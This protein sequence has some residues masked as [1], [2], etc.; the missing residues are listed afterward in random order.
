MYLPIN[1]RVAI[2]DNEVK[3]VKPLFQIFS[4][5]RI[6]YTFFDTSDSDF[7]PSETEN[8]NDIRLLFLDLNFLDK[9]T[10]DSKNVKSMLVTYLKRVISKNNFPYLIILWSTQETTYYEVVV[11]IFENDLKDRAPI[12]IERFIKSDYIDHEGNILKD[13]DDNL[14]NAIKDI[15]TKHQAYSTLVY[16]ENKVHKSADMVLQNIFNNYNNDEWVNKAN[17]I[18]EKLS[19]GYLG[20]QNHKNS[21]YI[22]RTKGSLQAFNN[23]FYDTLETQINTL[24]NIQQQNLLEFDE[25]TLSKD[26]ILD[27][28]N[29]KLIASDTELKLYYTGIVGEDTN[30]KSDAI[31]KS[32]FTEALDRSAMENDIEG[33]ED[34]NT[35]AKKKH[36]SNLRDSIRTDWKKIYLVVT[37]LCDTVQNKHKNIRTV[38]GFIIEKKFK[39]YIDEKS[40]AIY[41]SPPFY[42]KDSEKSFVLVL[43]F[44]YFFTF[45]TNQK[46]LSN[47]KFITP[48]FRLRS[49][50]IAEIQSK[51]ARHVNRQGILYVE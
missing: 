31:F 1:G 40:E 29:F 39:K 46:V 25:S 4:K 18:I 3:E 8:S 12:S 42:M 28:L 35:K 16:W 6:P 30:P 48:I 7:I 43:N 10:Q 38:K 44:R 49:S 45:T 27:T 32:I 36:S 22:D 50:I 19:Q 17:F 37:P 21:G 11:D 47:L 13:G 15:Y 34:L 14:I 24:S 51:L 9:T 41:I 2:M 5:H 26:V 33:F 23:I 20:F